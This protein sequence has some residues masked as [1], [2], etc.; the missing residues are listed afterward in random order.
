VSTVRKALGGEEN[1]ET[2]I[3]TIQRH[4]YR[5][6]YAVTRIVE[7]ESAAN[8]APGTTNVGALTES[9]K[10]RKTLLGVLTVGLVVLVV[11]LWLTGVFE[12]SLSKAGG[13]PE[14]EIELL[15]RWKWRLDKREQPHG[16]V[17]PSEQDGVI[18]IPDADG[19]TGGYLWPEV[20]LSGFRQVVLKVRNVRGGGNGFHLELKYERDWLTDRGKVWIALHKDQDWHEIQV[21][22]RLSKLATTRNLNYL[23][24]SDHL[25]PF[26]V[27]A[28]ILR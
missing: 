1:S 18:T 19:W 9:P 3:E 25:G 20:K 14:P 7:E 10:Q 16:T 2:Y 26:Q 17:T 8:G 28:L 23:A 22:L 12:R 13:P 24:F 15:D 6:S 27:R 21:P 4:G 5:F 11:S